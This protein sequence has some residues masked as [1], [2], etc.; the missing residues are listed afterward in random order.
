[1][2]KPVRI[3]LIGFLIAALIFVRG[4]IAPYFYDP[5]HEFFK[6]EYLYNSVPSMEIGRYF[7]HLFL[8]YLLNT[9]LSLAV[10]KLIFKDKS[11]LV[12]A[13]K[14]YVIAFV[15]LSLLLYFML[16]FELTINYMFIFYVRRFLI[17]PLFLF[18]LLPAIY[19]QKIMLKK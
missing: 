8:R 10:I 14:F 18:I 7:L 15:V 2:N 3:L 16:K 19:Y 5:L 17:Q 6:N 9:L 13:F 1:M 4:F 11:T 12:F